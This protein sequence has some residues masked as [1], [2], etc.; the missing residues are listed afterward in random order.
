MQEGS[1]KAI[2]AAFLANL[3]IAIAKFIGFLITRSAGMLAEAVHS[4]ADTGNQGLLML[5]SKRAKQDATPRHPFGF[6]SERYFWA[7]IVALVMFSLGGL[8]AMYE[9]VTKLLHPHETDSIGVAIGILVAAIGLET[10]SLVTAVR[11]AAAVKPK[12]VS[13]VSFVRYSKSPELPVVL[14]EDTAAEFGLVF[15]LIGLVLSHI[16]G[17]P[18]WDAAGSLAIGVLLVAVAIV[19]GV[20]MKGLLVG[21]AASLDQEASISR[22]IVAHPAV[23]RLI[24][25]RTLHLG[26]D[27]LLVAAKLEFDRSLTI[28]LL[29]E[30]IDSVEFDIRQAVAIARVIYIE[31][32]VHRSIS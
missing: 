16:T 10:Y 8:F 26:P 9:G 30:A 23:S 5:G 14:L 32:D 7:F 20:K 13:W 17:S 28:D 11:E 1:R 27:E 3:G 6:G 12:S 19:L 22:A 2:I 18:R 24:H 29:A 25:M 15:A 4:L 21:E 31:P